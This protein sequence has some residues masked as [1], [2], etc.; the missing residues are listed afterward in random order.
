MNPANL[1]ILT[2]CSRDCDRHLAGPDEMFDN[3][4]TN[5]TGGAQNETLHGKLETP[6]KT[7]PFGDNQY[8]SQDNGNNRKGAPPRHRLA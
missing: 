6:Q 1:P 8:Q 4:S 2:C 5:D 3:I 7:L